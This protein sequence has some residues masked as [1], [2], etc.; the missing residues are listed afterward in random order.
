MAEGLEAQRPLR[1][2][3]AVEALHARVR[4]RVPRLTGDRPPAADIAALGAAIRE[5]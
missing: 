4:A 3:A 1:S 5:G 2:S